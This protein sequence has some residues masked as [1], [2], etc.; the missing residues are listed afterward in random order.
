M[1][2]AFLKSCANTIVGNELNLKLSLAS[3]ISEGSILIEDYPG[4][5]KTTFAK[6]LTNNLGL[7]FKRIQFTSDLLPSDILGY[8]FFKGDE[9]VFQKGPIF[10][11][12]VLADE[13]NRGSAKSQSA[14]LE[15]MEEKNI[16][17]DGVTNK[18]PFPFFVIATQNPMDSSGTSML[19][20][21]QL[22]RFMI[23]FSLN[24]LDENQKKE[25]L[26]KDI[27]FSNRKDLNLDWDELKN[28]KNQINVND[29]I[30]EYVLEIEKQI[31]KTNS[32]LKISPRC[33]KQIIELS[34]GWA[35]IH[36]Q[37]Y[38]SHQDIKSVLPSILRHR[39]KFIDNENDKINFVNNE[40]LNHIKINK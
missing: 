1:L 11:N 7:N 35:L 3:I 34:K 14:F 10:T 15:A 8:N 32:N 18:L 2:N 33:L 29:N 17:I 13:L 4:T 36:D 25:I 6:T 31:K 20:D 27:N 16:T 37:N 30:F 9:Q 39:I 38:V 28:K 12:V 40:I 21:S 24:N 26:K 23:S 5:G 22:D 19:P